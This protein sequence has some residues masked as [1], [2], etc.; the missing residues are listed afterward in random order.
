MVDVTR[1]RSNPLGLDPQH[2]SAEVSH[3]GLYPVG[4]VETARHSQQLVHRLRPGQRM[5]LLAASKQLIEQTATDEPG[6]SGDEHA[7][8][9]APADIRRFS[10]IPPR[11]GL[12]PRR[13]TRLILRYEMP[14]ANG[15]RVGRG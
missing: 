8:R 9:P 3:D 14:L 6:R 13:L 10:A 15:P 5:H 12:Y 4:G 1:V 7:H 2:R 11:A